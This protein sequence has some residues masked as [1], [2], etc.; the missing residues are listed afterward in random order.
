MKN[1]LN[2]ALSFLFL[3][4]ST[5]VLAQD[6]LV[7]QVPPK[8]IEDLVNAP[9]TPAVSINATGDW[10]ILLERPGY[11]SI[12]ELA[13]PE[14]KIAGIRINPRTN[15]PSRSYSYNGLTFKSI[16]DNKEIP[17][18]GLPDKPLIENV[19]WSPNG[20]KIAFT[21]TVENGIELWFADL[22][23]GNAEKLTGATIND[24]L[25]GLPYR[26][27]SDNSLLYMAVDA[28]RGEIPAEPLTPSGPVV[29]QTTGKKAP[30]RT[31]QDLL[32]S[33]YDETLFDYYVTSQ[34]N[35]IEFDTKKITP[36][37]KPGIFSQ[38]S[39]SPDGSYIFIVEILRPYSYIV[40]YYRFTQTA[41][42]YDLAG[43]AV[44][45]IASIPA[46]E[47]IPKGFGAVRTG[48]R[49]F[50][51]RGDVAATIYW[52]E[53]LDEGDPASEVDFRD[54]AYWLAA[55]FD[56]EKTAGIDFVLRA[57]GFTW[58][59]EKLAIA[60]E[61]WWNTREI[62]TSRFVPG[63]A[64]SKETLFQRSFEDSYNDPGNFQTSLNAYGED[65]LLTDKAGKKLYL[66]GT[67]AS[68]EGNRPFLREFDLAKKTTKELWRSAA[69]FYEYPVQIIDMKKN[70]LLTRRESK[71]TPPNYFIRNTKSG[72]LSQLT[73]FPHPYP[74]LQGIEKQVVQYKRNDG[75]DLKG[76]L[77]L[78]AGYE[79]G[80]DPL[81][82]IMWAYPAEFKSSDAAG[83]VQGSP[84]EF[85]RLGWYSPLYFI[86]QG[87]AVFDDPS[88]P[89]VGEGDEEPNDT[90]REQ[91]VA[92][93]K[94][95]IDKLAEMGV[96]DPER[97]AIGGH[98]YGA[99]MTANMLAHSDLFA[100]GIARSGAYNRTLTPFGFQSEERTYWDA[101]EVYYTMSPFMHADKINEPLLMIHGE[102]DN[103]S[104]TF[105]MQSERMFAAIKGL[106]GNARLV[107]LPHESHGYRARESVL[108]M[109]WE[110]NEWLENYVKNKQE[111]KQE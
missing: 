90:F 6:D 73:D 30:V 2:L 106:G 108:H 70:L 109:L 31:Y 86:T 19:S 20:Q 27:I 32:K 61:W 59:S 9:Q 14:L 98:S 85:I 23:S 105:P 45:N 49:N 54:R 68:A 83:Q 64:D 34:L 29:Q 76:D 66:T 74:Q 81:P 24:A 107:M 110:M 77:Y 50:S 35:F 99:F 39:P 72:K 41:D 67:G 33:P 95:A 101:P 60:N 17:V 28:S 103:N 1:L 48:P 11:P 100:A 15:G 52:V 79:D 18:A 22:A 42:I 13:Q 4:L 58:G 47:N 5:Q 104:G 53:A 38:V 51:W 26:W 75:L 3:G 62:I 44:K 25:G 111:A 93:G 56:G 21:N 71:E 96:G 8:A 94:A 89:V 55:P 57:G 78:P 46:A 102:A 7:Y 97:V 82:V 43:N 92:N 12:G 40:P 84:Y 65:V 10:M 63:Q 91:L 88:M 87:Y 80:D 16:A 37:L 36:F 69:P